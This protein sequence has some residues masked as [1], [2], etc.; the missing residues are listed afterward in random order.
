MCK[1][2]VGNSVTG[3][4]KNTVVVKLLDHF[5]DKIGY[6][7]WMNTLSNRSIIWTPD[8]LNRYINHLDV[9]IISASTALD[10][11]YLMTSTDFIEANINNISWGNLCFN[12]YVDWTYK[13]NNQYIL[14][15]KYKKYIKWGYLLENK[16]LKIEEDF[17]NLYKNVMNDN[18]WSSVNW[19]PSLMEKFPQKFRN[20]SRFKYVDWEYAIFTL[21]IFSTGNFNLHDLINNTTLPWLKIITSTNFIEDNAAEINWHSFLTNEGVPWTYKTGGKYIL[22][23]RYKTQILL[24]IRSL[25][26]NNSLDF[27]VD[28]IETYKEFFEWSYFADNETFQWTDE[29]L[30]RYFYQDVM[31]VQFISGHTNFPWT[32]KFINENLESLTIW[33]LMR[34]KSIKFNHDLIERFIYKKDFSFSEKTN[35]DLSLQDIIEMTDKRKAKYHHCGKKCL[36]LCRNIW[37]DINDSLFSNRSIID[38]LIKRESIEALLIGVIPTQQN[39][40]STK[41]ECD[42]TNFTKSEL[43]DRHLLGEIFNFIN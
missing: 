30:E 2:F 1:L 25:L 39:L 8:L 22:I 3:Q 11:V 34:N 19:T 40:F 14:I 18:Y 4:V 38:N 17:I 41:C 15:E 13:K 32:S 27:T 31:K 26:I 9:E 37:H 35:I 16:G 23:E 33:K 20:A 43:F 36:F 24:N 10:W 7:G 29:H 5:C 6:I 42:F 21:N 12:K 28:F